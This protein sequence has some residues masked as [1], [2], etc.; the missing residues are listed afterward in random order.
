MRFASRTTFLDLGMRA[1][2]ASLLIAVSQAA[3]LPAIAGDALY[4]ICHPSVQLSQEELRDVFLGEKTFAGDVRLTPADNRAA[5]AVFLERVLKMAPAKYSTTW[6]KKSFRDGVN[7]PPVKGS[8][9]ETI[10]FVRHQVGACSY[11]TTAPGSGVHI[12]LNATA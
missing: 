3:A 2:L 1:A 6:T 8:D 4:V 7:P 5:Q 11:V 12:V 9:A 10:E